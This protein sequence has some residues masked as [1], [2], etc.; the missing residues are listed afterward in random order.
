VMSGAMD[1]S[2]IIYVVASDDD[3]PVC[4]QL[5]HSDGILQPQILPKSSLPFTGSAITVCDDRGNDIAKD[6]TIEAYEYTV[7][8]NGEVCQLNDTRNTVLSSNCLAAERN[9]GRSRSTTEDSV[10][11][12]NLVTNLKTHGVQMT[13]SQD[14]SQ[15]G[16]HDVLGLDKINGTVTYTEDLPV[17]FDLVTTSNYVKHFLDDRAIQASTIETTADTNQNN[18]TASSS[19][20]ENLSSVCVNNGTLSNS[21]QSVNCSMPSV[22]SLPEN[23]CDDA[24]HVNLAADHNSRTMWHLAKYTAVNTET[25]AA[26]CKVSTPLRNVVS[27]DTVSSLTGKHLRPCASFSSE[28]CLNSCSCEHSSACKQ[29]ASQSDLPESDS[30]SAASLLTNN[31]CNVKSIPSCVSSVVDNEATSLCVHSSKTETPAEELV[32]DCKLDSSGSHFTDQMRKTSGSDGPKHGIC[33]CGPVAKCDFCKMEQQPDNHILADVTNYSLSDLSVSGAC[34][35]KP[36]HDDCNQSMI[37]SDHADMGSKFNIPLI[38]SDSVELPSANTYGI[39]VKGAVQQ[40]DVESLSVVMNT[41]DLDDRG[42]N[43][44]EMP[45]NS[46]ISVDVVDFTEKYC[47]FSSVDFDS[48]AVEG[49]VE[50]KGVE[51]LIDD[52]DTNDLNDISSNRREMLSNCGISVDVVNRS[53]SERSLPSASI[54]SSSVD[55]VQQ[56]DV[57]LNDQDIMGGSEQEMPFK[58][59]NSFAVVNHSQTECSLPSSAVEDS[60]QQTGVTSLSDVINTNDLDYTGSYKREMLSNSSISVDVDLNENERLFPSA[61]NDDSAVENSIQHKDVT[62]LRDVINTSTSDLDVTSRNKKDQNFADAANTECI[63]QLD[64]SMNPAYN[65]DFAHDMVNSN[66]TSVLDTVVT[67]T[68]KHSTVLEPMETYTTESMVHTVDQEFDDENNANVECRLQPPF[69][70]CHT[71]T[72]CQQDLLK[73]VRNFSDDIH[74]MRRKLCVLHRTKHRLRK[75]LRNRLPAV[76]SNTYQSQ[77]YRVL[78]LLHDT[79]SSKRLRLEAIDAELADREMILQH[80]EELMDLRLQ[81]VEQREQALHETERLL[82]QAQY[83]ILAPQQEQ[84]EL[85]TDVHIEPVHKHPAIEHKSDV[86]ESNQKNMS[87]QRCTFCIPKHSFNCSAEIFITL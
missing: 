30:I 77:M 50:Q 82:S 72:G 80:R 62:L 31:F 73:A 43:K 47:L 61:S 6:I 56:K 70:A 19:Y 8:E 22:P 74:E 78:D 51:S 24:S 9:A 60:V 85:M 21:L 11:E 4:L 87:K 83:C 18:D 28:Y 16:Q 67:L 32:A 63:L 41:S 29:S 64:C 66:S 38:V 84:I 34:L 86:A 37:L 15:A 81:R 57:A 3:L 59:S 45:S 35:N 48:S 14:S 26:S 39:V 52:M 79:N 33:S 5:L 25:V 65:G 20:E 13:F 69:T 42:N 54:D 44:R 46:S 76:A 7:N 71:Y 23:L 75:L 17:N 55:S 36:N 27:C 1:S 53:E 2:D 49:S 10:Q 40:K 12:P 68:S 58:S